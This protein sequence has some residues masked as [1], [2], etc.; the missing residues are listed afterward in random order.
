LEEV[1]IGEM[2]TFDAFALAG[3]VARAT[4]RIRVVVGPLPVATR[5]PAA[6]AMGVNS[7]SILGGRPADLALGASTPT[8]VAGWHGR[9]W[10]DQVGLV[11]AALDEVRL[12][13][14]GERAG[15]GFRLRSPAGA[16][17]QIAVAAFG[18]RML[19][20]A[21]PRADRVV[22]NIVTPAQ[23]RRLT[24]APGLP[25]ATV[26]VPG[27]LD[28]GPAAME[29]LRR[30][31]AVYLA[32]PGYGE[33]FSEAGFGD[34][35]EA[36]R[37]GGRPEVPEALVLAVSALGGKTQLEARIEEYHSAG[38]DTVAV[39]PATAEDPGGERLLRAL[40]GG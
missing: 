23:V 10:G 4:V 3:A 9:V 28:P 5:S 32:Q 1:W 38:A 16:G 27:A 33:M 29:Q 37:A 12:L 24:R 19:R 18:P 40:G 31:L 6:L 13:L 36:A 20:L 2:A 7:I 17:T 39:V 26:W 15:R 22:F 34:V 8:V 14:A 11:N 30:E 25:P 35:V 21:A